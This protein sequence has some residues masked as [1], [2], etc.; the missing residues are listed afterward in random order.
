V[1]IGAGKAL[2]LLRA[3][4]EYIYVCTVKAFDISRVKSALQ[5]VFRVAEDTICITIA[6][7]EAYRTPR[8]IG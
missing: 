3:Q 7:I 4:M 2:F 8:L 1:K 5:Y 6:T